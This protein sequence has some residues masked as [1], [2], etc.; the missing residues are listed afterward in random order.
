MLIDALVAFGGNSHAARSARAKLQWRDRYGRWVEMGRGVKFKLRRSNGSVVSV[1]GKFVGATDNAGFGQVYVQND[2]NGLRDGFYQV[3]SAN[4]SEMLASL[5]QDYLASRGIKVGYHADGTPVGDRMDDAIQD[6]ATIVRRDT[7]IGWNR[8][9]LVPGGM[10]TDDGQYKIKPISVPQGRGLPPVTRYVVSERMADGR[11]GVTGGR[12]DDISAALKHVDALDSSGQQAPDPVAAIPDDAPE[13]QQQSADEQARAAAKAAIAAYDADGSASRLIDNGADSVDVIDHLRQVSPQFK[14]DDDRWRENNMADR[15]QPADKAEHDRMDAIR[16]ALAKAP[17]TP[18]PNATQD[19]TPAAPEAQ[20]GGIPSNIIDHV[21]Q[22]GGITLD[23]ATGDVAKDG[24]IVATQ[25]NSDIIPQDEFF[26]DAQGIDRVA[27]YVNAN[28]DALGQGGMR[29]GIWHDKKNNEVVLDTVEQVADRDQAIA[30]G[31]QRNQQAIYDVAN[32]QEIDTGGNGDRP[33]APAPAEQQQPDVAPS[34]EQPGGPDAGPDQAVGNTPVPGVQGDEQPAAAPAG[35]L[36][37]LGQPIPT[38]PSELQRRADFLNR[39][40]DRMPVDSPVYDDTV[41]ARDQVNARLRGETQ[42]P[43]EVTPAQQPTPNAPSAPAE[44][45][46]TPEAPT[47]EASEPYPAGTKINFR[48]MRGEVRGA[49]VIGPTPNNP[50]NVNVRLDQPRR[51]EPNAISVKRANIVPNEAPQAPEVPAQPVDNTPDVVPAAPET[52]QS[53][54]IPAWTPPAPNA[55]PQEEAINSAQNYLDMAERTLEADRAAAERDPNQPNSADGRI[56]FKPPTPAEAAATRAFNQEQLRQSQA[57][58]DAAEHRLQALRA[59]EEDPG[60]PGSV[61]YPTP[62]ERQRNTAPY[63]DGPL[64]PNDPAI[65]ASRAIDAAVEEAFSGQDMAPD[66]TSKDDRIAEAVGAIQQALDSPPDPARTTPLDLFKDVDAVS[67]PD[68]QF[69]DGPNQDALPATPGDEPEPDFGYKDATEDYDDMK[70]PPTDEQRNIVQAVLGGNNVGVQALAGTGKTSTLELIANRIKKLMPQ[71]RILYIAFNKSVQEEADRRMPGNVESRT[72]DSLAWQGIS[73]DLT[74]KSRNKDALVRPGDIARHLGIQGDRNN[75]ADDIA[76]ALDKVIKKYAISEDDNIGPQHFVGADIDPSPQNLAAANAWWKDINDKDGQLRFRNDHA[77]KIWALTRPD[78]SKLGSGVKNPAHVIFF[79][80]A[81]DIN[82]VM[83]K[84]VRDQGIQKVYVGDQNQAIYGFRGAVDELDKAQVDFSLPLRKSWRFGPQ[85]AGM[86]NRFLAMLGARHK[87]VGGGRD[88]I[89]H[90]PGTMENADAVLTRTNAGAIGAII[91]EVGRGRVVGV[92][93]KF[94]EELTNVVNTVRWLQSDGA[95]RKPSKIADDLAGYKS[96]NEVE[97]DI[98]LDKADSKVQTYYNLVQKYGTDGLQQALDRAVIARPDDNAN[99]GGSFGPLDLSEGAEGSLDKGMKYFVRDGKVYIGGNT[100]MNKDQIKQAGFSRFDGATKQWYR[101]AANPDA[102]RQGLE[103][104]RGNPEA[105]PKIDVVVTTAHKAKGLEWDRVRI[106]N[107]FWGPRSEVDPVTGEERVIMPEPEELRLAYVA[108]TRAAL[109][110]DP[111]ALNWIKDYTT[112]ADEDPDVPAPNVNEPN[113]PETPEVPSE[114]AAEPSPA[115]TPEP[116]PEPQVSPT[117]AESPAPAPE[118]S[119]VAEPPQTP[120][121]PP[122]APAPEPSP[123]PEPV[124]PTPAPEPTPAPPAPTPAP[125]PA[126]PEAA[127]DSL[128]SDDQIR[129]IV[130]TMFP[131]GNPGMEEAMRRERDRQRAERGVQA[132]PAP[133]PTAVP[134]PTPAP[135][136]VERTPEID[137]AN[138]SDTEIQDEVDQILE[139]IDLNNRAGDP[140]PGLGMEDRLRDLQDEQASRDERAQAQSSQ[141]EPVAP[142]ESAPNEATQRSARAYVA[143]KDVSPE[144]RSQIDDIIENGNQTAVTEVINELKNT[145][146][147]PDA[148]TTP[149]TEVIPQ[150]PMDEGLARPSVGNIADP[151]LIVQDIKRNHPDH[152]VLANGD[153]VIGSRTI[154]NKRYDL[155]VRRTRREQFF[156]YMMETNLDTGAV[157]ISKAGSDTHSYRALTTKMNRGKVALAGNPE[158]W[159]NRRRNIETLGPDGR[160]NQAERIVE[161]DVTLDSQRDGQDAL[162]DA[163]DGVAGNP[164]FAPA[165]VQAVVDAQNNGT[166]VPREIQNGIVDAATTGAAQNAQGDLLEANGETDRPA[167]IAYDGQQLKAGDWVDWTDWRA[168]SPTYGQVFRGQIRSLRER[169]QDAKGRYIYTDHVYAVFP[170]YNRLKGV[171]PSKQREFVSSNMRVVDSQNATLGEP[172]FAKQEELARRNRAVGNRDASAP[173]IAPAQRPADFGVPENPP[174]GQAARSIPKPASAKPAEPEPMEPQFNEDGLEIVRDNGTDFEKP[175][176]LGLLQEALVGRYLGVAPADIR[177]GDILNDN[178]NGGNGLAKVLSVSAND[179]GEIVITKVRVKDNDE[180]ERVRQ[181]FQPNGPRVFANRQG[182]ATPVANTPAPSLQVPEPIDRPDGQPRLART[183][184][185]D[186]LRNTARSHKMSDASRKVALDL[187]DNPDATRDQ[188]AS[189]IQ[190]I[191]QNRQRIPTPPLTPPRAQSAAQQVADATN[192]LPDGGGAGADLQA[193]AAHVSAAALPPTPSD[194]YGGQLV[195]KIKYAD[196][197]YTGAN[198]PFVNVRQEAVQDIQ[199]G[200]LIPKGVGADRHYFQVVDISEASRGYFKVRQIHQSDNHWAQGRV[201]TKYFNPR[202]DIT[203]VKRPTAKMRPDYWAPGQ[204]PAPGAGGNALPP[205]ARRMRK[206]GTILHADGFEVPERQLAAAKPDAATIEQSTALKRIYAAGDEL[207]RKYN[208]GFKGLGANN[209]GGGI[210]NER[211]QV[212]Q[213]R[214][215]SLGFVKILRDKQQ[216]DNELLANHMAAALGIENIEMV[217]LADGQT[218]ITKAIPGENA[219]DV[220]AQKRAI[221]NDFEAFPNAKRIGM[222]DFLIHNHDRHEYNWRITPEGEP[223]PIDHGRVSMETPGLPTGWNGIDRSGFVKAA[224]GATSGNRWRPQKSLIR[225]SPAELLSYRNELENMRGDFDA[226]GKGRWFKN[227]LNRLDIVINA[228]NG[229]L[230]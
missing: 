88:G 131:G 112:D 65:E 10:V 115:P 111:G 77:T 211:S 194:K 108:V 75:S 140:N 78:L 215:G 175:T 9:P 202:G 98:K 144:R 3:S 85:V 43:A 180:V 224:L 126:V 18:N 54:G 106:A 16:T 34:P 178:F 120:P 110:L 105:R 156:P 74:G 169:G 60:I 80:E 76:R 66:G 121:A 219:G 174:A 79:D 142:V 86:G 133:A 101:P 26:N 36:D 187:A 70:F 81:Q 53:E 199:V 220:G 173:V 212:I 21:R 159:M 135:A 230:S 226:R 129:R 216:F 151:N 204:A 49:T 132:E 95:M 146:N 201:S 196:V 186:L 14:A 23:L 139:Q 5:S 59:G 158:R 152:T 198:A 141:P 150:T 113:A 22:N 168:N 225:F 153:V 147:I 162:A 229:G 188:V 83:A 213:F 189:V 118:P 97:R 11:Y 15:L 167:H 171:K 19:N 48:N 217:G 116:T 125:A 145:P 161:G 183:L 28:K 206:Y 127:P 68:D 177:P 6:E 94:K 2:P 172:F 63:I 155:V 45:V 92:S 96:W 192:A 124:A 64:T 31:Q 193:A 185:R 58:R 170:E 32:D 71:K 190:D 30:L 179:N 119:P 93:E 130:E 228:K 134:E 24:Y 227:V 149:R 29:L 55:T 114:P 89:V 117:P 138:M 195:K 35:D 102:D 39:R 165:A 37:A 209:A 52:P 176:Q 223:Y 163:V 62:E 181:V 100:F 41:A 57:R 40:A 128:P 69:P 136:P 203:N 12:Q 25:G 148:V 104:L 182:P 214:D 122:A 13:P 164:D 222:L 8:D 4:G 143:G 20:Q 56:G 184:L 67:D 87:V 123:S 210:D 84:V 90:E 82:P 99:N 46:P 50:N 107:D 33:N 44:D 166:P 160:R 221:F 218:L 137:P 197:K 7:P 103:Q 205:G 17:K 51:G 27:N 157:R 109:E 208:E 154:G 191:I 207:A 73:K 38:D 61:L 42:A 1:M 47:P 72:G 91:D 200:D